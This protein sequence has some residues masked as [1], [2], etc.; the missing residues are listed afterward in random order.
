[1]TS[2]RKKA[3]PALAWAEEYPCS[4]LPGEIPV[5]LLKKKRNK[6]SQQNKSTKR[7]QRSNLYDN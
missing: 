1:M 5:H 6:N 4:G 7:T 2:R 3:D